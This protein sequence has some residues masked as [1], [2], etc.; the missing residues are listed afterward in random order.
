[1]SG[2]TCM[3]KNTARNRCSIR[4]KGYDYSQAGFYFVTIC[5][6]N[7]ECVFGEI[8]NGKMK[9]NEFGS[10]AFNEWNRNPIARDNIINHAFVVMPKHIHGIIEITKPVGAYRDTPLHENKFDQKNNK[11]NLR[12]PSNNLGV[13]FGGINR[14]LPNA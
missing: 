14:R 7:K 10:I 13:W 2:H 8:R 1:M 11:S 3:K 6:Q 5:T 4:L 12:S 9:L